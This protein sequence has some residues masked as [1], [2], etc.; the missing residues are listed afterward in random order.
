MFVNNWV[1]NVYL[2]EISFFSRKK[3]VAS[4]TLVELQFIFEIRSTKP[5]FEEILLE[6]GFIEEMRTT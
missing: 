2:K 5:N 4:A 6:F 3:L 1:I